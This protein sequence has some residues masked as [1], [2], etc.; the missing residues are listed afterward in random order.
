MCAP[1]AIVVAGM[2]GRFPQSDNL[3]EFWENLIGGVDMVTS[4]ANRWPADYF[5]LPPRCGTMKDLTKFDA[6]FFGVSAK[7]ADAIGPA[8]RMLYEV[9]FE[10]ISDAGKRRNLLAY[11]AI[12]RALLITRP[13]LGINPESLR[14]SKTGVYVGVSGTDVDEAKVGTLLALHLI[15]RFRHCSLTTNCSLTCD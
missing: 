3:L 2:S 1:N 13:S 15:S 4:S 14:G 9:I 6:E 10:A 5:N 12:I 8:Q 11:S 7:Q